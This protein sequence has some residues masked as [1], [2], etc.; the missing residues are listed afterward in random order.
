MANA[1]NH[2]HGDLKAGKVGETSIHS[3]GWDQLLRFEFCVIHDVHVRV[4]R[5]Y[6]RSVHIPL[7]LLWILNDILTVLTTCFSVAGIIY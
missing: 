2:D 6:I 4:S 5:S 3:Q 1:V 7:S